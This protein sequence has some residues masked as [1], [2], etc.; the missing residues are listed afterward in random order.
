MN[1]ELRLLAVVRR[2]KPNYKKGHAHKIFPNL[3]NHDFSAKKINTKW[4]TDFT[5]LY[6]T[7]GSKRYNCSILGLHNRSIVANITD[8]EITSSLA[9]R[10]LAIAAQLL[11]F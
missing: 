8:K 4:C 7:N 10:T 5:Y 3:V 9:I 2:K 1:H 6:L 11:P